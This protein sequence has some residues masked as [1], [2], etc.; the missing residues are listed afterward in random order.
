MLY[1][2]ELLE[3]TKTPE[4]ALGFVD[5]IAYGVSGLTA[6]GNVERLQTILSWR[7]GR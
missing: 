7:N 4:L 2:A 5:D 3:I 1:N 6:Q